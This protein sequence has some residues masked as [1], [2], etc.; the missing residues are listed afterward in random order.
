MSQPTD[1]VSNENAIICVDTKNHGIVSYDVDTNDAIGL[2][3]ENTPGYANGTNIKEWRFN[4]PMGIT[5]D[6]EG[7][8]IIADTGNDCIRKMTIG[9]V[10]NNV[11]TIAGKQP[12]EVTSKLSMP[13]SVCMLGDSIIVADTGNHCIR[14]LIK[15]TDGSYTMIIIAGTHGTPGYKNGHHS[16]FNRPVKVAVWNG[17]IYVADSGNSRIRMIVD[18]TP[19]EGEFPKNLIV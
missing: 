18:H 10:K 16:L 12:G 19:S 7:N 3:L 4:T 13:M 11:T 1:M 2:P 6:E 9:K 15:K 8:I 14:K 5:T 17:N